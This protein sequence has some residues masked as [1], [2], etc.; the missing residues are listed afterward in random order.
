MPTFR[1]VGAEARARLARRGPG[2]DELAPYR[3]ALASLEGDAHLELAPEDGETMRAM[4]LRV[5]RA[6]KQVGKEVSYGETQDGT[7][8]VWLSNPTPP[9]RRRRRRPQAITA[10]QEADVASSGTVPPAG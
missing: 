10:P 1:T 4:K 6:S 5:S 9:R 3:E 7:L 2:K 8:M